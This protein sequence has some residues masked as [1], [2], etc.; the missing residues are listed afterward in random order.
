MGLLDRLLWSLGDETGGG[1]DESPR[2]SES[3][4]DAKSGS[5]GS[6]WD[7]LVDEDEAIGRA[8]Q[9]TIAAGEAVRAPSVDGRETVGFRAGEGP[10]RSTV[11][12]ADGEMLT[13]YPAAEG[14]EHEFAADE[15]IPWANGVEAQLRG[16]LGPASVAL[17]PT[18]FFA[19]HDQTFEGDRRVELAGLAYYCAPQS[20]ASDDAVAGVDGTD[21]ADG[22]GVVGFAPFD[23]GDVD[24]YVFRTRAKAVTATAFDGRAVYR[25]RAP[26]FRRDGED[27]DVSLYAAD[28]VLDGVVP[29]AGDDLEGVLWLQGR[30]E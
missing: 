14:I 27:V 15:T 4:R 12:T 11:V 20:G 17:F 28:R 29:D 22:D 3:D 23:R 7:A 2:Q 16:R 18:N 9:R 13:A 5:H 21:A 10:V 8:V 6:H 25:I 30:V 19:R 26:L 1:R 24:D